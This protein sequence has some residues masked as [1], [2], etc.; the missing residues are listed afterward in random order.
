MIKTI[1]SF[2]DKKS[3][4]YLVYML[5]QVEYNPKKMLQWLRRLFR[6]N[7]PLYKV[8][9]RKKLILTKRAKLLKRTTEIITVLY[10][11]I[12]FLLYIYNS[13]SSVLVFIFLMYI[14]F[15]FQV[16]VMLGL[17]FLGYM[18]VVVPQQKRLLLGAK[19]IFSEHSAVK[20]AVLGSY[21][22]TTMK[23]ILA[24]ILSE[25]K[26]VAATPGNMNVSIS[27][28]RFAKK[29][30]GKE[31]I[32]IVEFGEGE[33][34]DIRRMTEMLQPDYAF[35]TGLASNHLD[36]YTNLEAIVNDFS[37]I[38]DTVSS[39]RVFVSGESHLL[40]SSLSREA[41][42][43]S[44][45]EVMG[46]K[47]SNID[48]SIQGT[49][50]VMKKNKNVFHITT[51]LLGRH[52]I[53]PIA[54]SAALAVALGLTKQQIESGCMNIV[55]Y[56]HRMKP[57]NIN[58]AWIIDDTYNGNLEG[59]KVGLRLLKELD[60]KRKW[61]I[62]PGLVDQGSEFESVHRQLGKAIA[63]ANPDIVVLMEN[64]ARPVIELAIT[65]HGFSGQIRVESDPLQFY[66][67][68]E[69]MVAAGDI[70]LMQNDWTDNY[71]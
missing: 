67:S 23:E 10:V 62:T 59:M 63:V 64:S 4:H 28:A 34:G 36:Q 52:Q 49:S 35:I 21:G 32:L 60:A 44:G 14:S 2:L 61:Y 50:F 57:I 46:W 55:P 56:E 70:V 37:S 33:P 51:R 66:T 5:Q 24:T 43:Y 8:E 41:V 15:W 16:I 29:L 68:I 6:S 18:L 53:A 3:T 17:S 27:H 47:I 38:F 71:N 19:R 45:K 42:W 54:A 20:I 26:D 69:H 7:T 39:D 58:G 1:V 9:Y 11:T 30:N 40:T 25:G 65:E 22:K 31:D 13:V 48:T 12:V